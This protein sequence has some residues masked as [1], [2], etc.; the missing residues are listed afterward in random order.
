M[1]ASGT[2]AATTP[3][4]FSSEYHDDTFGLV[5]SGGILGFGAKDCGKAVFEFIHRYRRLNEYE[6]LSD[7]NDKVTAL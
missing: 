7:K 6:V 4:H 2:L 1:S 3:F 5:R